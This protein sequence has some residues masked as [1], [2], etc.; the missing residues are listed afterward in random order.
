MAKKKLI[1][2][3]ALSMFLLTGCNANKSRDPEIL[4][5]YN[6]YKANGGTLDYDT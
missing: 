6:A 2:L 4:E 3:V 5:V 1:S